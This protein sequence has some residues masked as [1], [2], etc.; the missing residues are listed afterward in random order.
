MKRVA[1]FLGHE[2]AAYRLW[3]LDHRMIEPYG[4]QAALMEYLMP[5]QQADFAEYGGFVFERE[6]RPPIFWHISCFSPF[7]C[8]Q[9]GRPLSR[10]QWM[11]AGKLV[12]QAAASEIS[13]IV[14]MP[15]RTL[16]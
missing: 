3:W 5:E 6:S 11:I 1:D 16:P 4:D 12:W 7:G 8:L 10:V 14:N 2:S 13:L 15:G 9:P